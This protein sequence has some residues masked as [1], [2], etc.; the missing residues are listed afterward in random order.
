MIAKLHC[1]KEKVAQIRQAGRLQKDEKVE[2]AK[3]LLSS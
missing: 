3:V 1:H 2:A